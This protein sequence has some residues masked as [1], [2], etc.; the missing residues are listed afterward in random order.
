MIN[1]AVS[2]RVLGQYP[3][4]MATSLAIEGTRG[5][6]PDR[7]S[8]DVLAKYEVL[9]VNLKTLFR[10]LY[11]A[12]ARDSVLGVHPQSFAEAMVQEMDQLDRLI[13][14]E[15]NGKTSV[16]FYLCDY[17][18]IEIQYRHALVRGDTTPLQS[19]YTKA[20]HE[21]LRILL[22]M[23]KDHIKLYKLHI[24]DTEN[25]KA[26]MLTHYPFDLTT[27]SF[28]HLSL[29]E[30]HTGTIKDKNL[31]YTKFNNGK[32][33]S[34]IPFNLGFLQI[35]GDAE[36]FR[37]QSITMRK[38]LIELATKYRWSSVT[39]RDKIVFSLGLSPDKF[40]RDTVMQF[41]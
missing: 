37:P 25:R 33:L 32:D 8:K 22:P 30:S 28:A 17:F 1:T 18:G 40:L 36:H 7:P 3:I 31:W 23:V 34:V 9:W 26:L 21:T 27:K 41:F 35:F 39:T 24:T 15:S 11:N 38:A 29:L 10:N 14:A 5:I 16:V 20:M 12:V 19:A 13:A 4:S 6:H 2:D